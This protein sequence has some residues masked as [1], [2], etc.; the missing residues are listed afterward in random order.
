VESG[1]TRLL[2]FGREGVTKKVLEEGLR[3]RLQLGKKRVEL[4]AVNVVLCVARTSGL[5]AGQG[6][7]SGTHIEIKDL[8]NEKKKARTKERRSAGAA[9]QKM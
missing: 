9:V 6:N 4:V 1:F 7:K 3:E 5:Q 2:S 8:E